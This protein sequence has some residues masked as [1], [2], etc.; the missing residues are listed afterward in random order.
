[1]GVFDNLKGLADQA[2]EKATELVDQH[3]D[4]VE[5]G[6]EKAGQLADE[7]TGGQHTDKIQQG[8]DKAREA[9]DGLDGQ[10]DDLHRPGQG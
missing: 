7:R 2:K 3:G 8:V 6:L 10:Q 5:Q 4:K 1:M 9:L